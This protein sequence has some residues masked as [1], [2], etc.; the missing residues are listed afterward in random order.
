[1]V[2]KLFVPGMSGKSNSVE[3][4][5]AN[6]S[7]IQSGVRVPPGVSEDILGGMQSLKEANS[8]FVLKGNNRG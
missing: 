6:L 5:R 2:N 7:G 4:N 3:S 1:M 8:L